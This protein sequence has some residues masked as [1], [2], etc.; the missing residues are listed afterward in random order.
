MKKKTKCN[1]TKQEILDWW[2]KLTKKQ[3]LRCIEFVYSIQIYEDIMEEH[4]DTKKRK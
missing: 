3:Q 2:G 4:Y 1:K